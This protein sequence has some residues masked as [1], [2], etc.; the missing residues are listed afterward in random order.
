[1]HLDGAARARQAE[2]PMPESSFINPDGQTT[3]D[4]EPAEGACELE[5][6]SAPGERIRQV[7][8]TLL[9]AARPSAIEDGAVIYH[10]GEPIDSVLVIEAGTVKLLRH[11]PNGRARIVRLH[12]R[13]SLLGLNGMLE[14]D[15]EHTA[16]AVG[17]VDVLQVPLSDVRRIREKDPK[18]YSRLLEAWNSYL[19]EAD[20]WITRFSTG[21]IRARVARLLSFLAMRPTEHDDGRGQVSLL[22]GEDMANILGV[23]PESVSRNLAELKRQGVLAPLDGMTERYDC[24]LKALETLGLD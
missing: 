7:L 19:T 16:V 13:G 1:M 23:T 8:P 5:R 14:P 24:D 3:E 17:D 11:L 20:I 18:N 2:D 6:I 21:S 22:S 12:T 15:H 10:E 4:L 9:E